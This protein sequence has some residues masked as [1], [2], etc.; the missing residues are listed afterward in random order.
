MILNAQRATSL[1]YLLTVHYLVHILEKAVDDLEG[2][3]CSCQSFVVG[4]S[5]EPLEYRLD[6]LLSEEL[7]KKF[8]CIAFESDNIL[9]H[10]RRTHVIFRP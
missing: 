4:E 3:C 8:F 1:V 7:L 6:V 5:V 10:R 2:L 9:P